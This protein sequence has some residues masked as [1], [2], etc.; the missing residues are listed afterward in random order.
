MSKREAF[1][2][3]EKELC[4]QLG[5]KDLSEHEIEVDL[6]FMVQSGKEIR[7][8]K[9]IYNGMEL[10]KA[11]NK[12][13]KN[14]EDQTYYT[15]SPKAP[16]ILNVAVNPPKIRGNLSWMDSGGNPAGKP[17]GT[18]NRVSVKQA[19]ERLGANPA[20]FLVGVLTGDVGTLKRYRVKDPQNVTLAQKM[21]C[22]ELLLHKLVPN[23]KPADIDS[24]GEARVE[25]AST[26]DKVQFHVIMPG[27]P[28]PIAVEGTKEELEELEEVGAE[29]F[30]KNRKV[31]TIPYDET[32]EEESMVWRI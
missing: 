23:L 15:E 2:I 12:S 4:R 13:A 17:K 22:A 31:E 32:N 26:D 24:D 21:K 16:Q 18:M 20:D 14:P 7:S 3:N 8:V 1:K 25:N 5:V 29:E 6:S 9:V 19:C 10:W 30:I 28:D 27:Q 11:F